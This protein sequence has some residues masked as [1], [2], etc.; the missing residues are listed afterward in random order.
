M[1]VE[2]TKDKIVKAA[3][4]LY[5]LDGC[6]RVTMDQIAAHLHISKRTLYVLFATKEKLLSA[7]LKEVHKEIHDNI[8]KLSLQV[9][10]PMLL[11]L[12]LMRNSVSIKHKYGMMLYDI[13][14][15]YPE[16]S[17][18]FHQIHADCF[19]TGLLD[20]L[21]IAQ[22]KNIIRPSVNL[23]ELSEMMIHLIQNNHSLNVE[24][25]SD[26][27]RKVNEAAFIFIRGLMTTEAIQKYDENEGRFRELTNLNF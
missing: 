6:K 20:T 9:D 27:M 11:T 2:E 3:T 23:E 26:Y 24:N 14:R 15:Y 19:R 17:G 8:H 4:E 7:C 12:F 21:R 25:K 18:T 1:T 5:M 13:D 22:S 10:E 16:I